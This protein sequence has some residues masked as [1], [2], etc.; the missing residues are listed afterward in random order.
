MPTADRKQHN[1]L[2]RLATA[3]SEVEGFPIMNKMFTGLHWSLQMSFSGFSGL[4]V[5]QVFQV[6]AAGQPG[7][8]ASNSAVNQ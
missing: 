8:A 5:F 7:F 2:T 1:R 3:V 6:A 4:Q